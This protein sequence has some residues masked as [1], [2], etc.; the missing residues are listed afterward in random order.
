MQI[1]LGVQLQELEKPC[2]CVKYGNGHLVQWSMQTAID[3]ISPPAGTTAVKHL[4]S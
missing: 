4:E 3:H 1:S 2:V